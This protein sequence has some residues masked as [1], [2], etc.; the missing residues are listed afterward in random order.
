LKYDIKLREDAQP[1]ANPPRRVAL[2]IQDELKKSLDD[3]EF[4]KAKDNFE[5][6]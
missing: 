4:R 3:L 1:V 6:H 2:K 5:D